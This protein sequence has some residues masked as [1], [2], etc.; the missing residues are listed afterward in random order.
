MTTRG[1]IDRARGGDGGGFPA[2]GTP[3]AGGGGGGASGEVFPTRFSWLYGG[4]NVHLCGSFT[5]WLET[6]PMAQE[7]NAD[8]SRTFTVVCDLPPGYHQYKFIV[9]GQWRHDESQAFIQDPLG[10]VNNWLYVKPSGGQTPPPQNAPTQAEAVPR[11]A[12]VPVPGASRPAAS[13]ES[14]GMDWMNDGGGRDA[15]TTRSSGALKSRRTSMDTNGPGAAMAA[16]AQSGEGDTSGARVMDFLQKHTAYEL[17]PESNKVVVLDTALPVRQAFHAFYEQ[18][19]YAA[20]LWDEKTRDFIGLLSAGDFIDI[21]RRLTAALS[22]REDLTDDDLDEYSIQVIR[23]EYEKEGIKMKPLISVRPEDSLY[24]VALTMT[25]AGVHN[26]PVLSHSSVC[27]AGGSVSTSNTTDCPQLLHMTNLAEVLA[28]LNRH[29]RGIPSALPLFSQPIGALPIGTWTERYGGS[30]S[31]PIPPLPA[32]IDEQ[33]LVKE[34]YPIRA[35]T[36]SASIEQ[37]F[38]VLHGISALPIVNEH[39][40]LMDLYARGD[41]IRLAANSAYRASISEMSVAQAL[42]ALRPTALN[43]QNDPSS[44]HYGRFSTCVRGDTLRTALEML[45][46]PNIRRL[47]VVDPVTKVV[48]GVVSLSDVF[49]FLIENA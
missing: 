28:C 34:L 11:S 20:P 46:L 12:P 10:N 24:H 44:T 21:M 14:G 48:E 1:S 33:Y 15:A 23:E 25:E 3:N 39:G 9:D 26:V 38:D 29:F 30:R 4:D 40:V 47:I 42:G 16:S 22:D 32:G 17:I 37:V 41:V 31:K 45:S 19:I 35:V 36:P 43:E 6:V 13:G 18:G 2:P 7:L 5:N 49:S 27:P 8:G